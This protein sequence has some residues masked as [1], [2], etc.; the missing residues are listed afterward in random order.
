MALMMVGTVAPFISS[1][2]AATLTSTG[3]GSTPFATSLQPLF[4]FLFCPLFS[5]PNPPFPIFLPPSIQKLHVEPSDCREVAA[6]EK[7]Y[8]ENRPR[9][10][11]VPRH[12]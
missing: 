9:L 8:R 4:P 3:T 11:G 12:A 5:R 10:L 2:P 6:V 7:W 1:E